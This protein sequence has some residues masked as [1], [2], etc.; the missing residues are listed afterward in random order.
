MVRNRFTSAGGQ[1]VVGDSSTLGSVTGSTMAPDSTDSD[2]ETHSLSPS[3]TDYP[4]HWGRQYHKYKENSYLY[5]ND[6]DEKDRLD[7]QHHIVKKLHGDR[8]FF[9]PVKDA[10]KILDIGTGTGIWPLELAESNL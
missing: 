8:L 7:F 9:A 10:R 6:E 3:M 2:G 4:T 5:P 1:E